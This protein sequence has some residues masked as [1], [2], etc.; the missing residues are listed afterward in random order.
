MSHILLNYAFLLFLSIY[1]E[2]HRELFFLD[3]KVTISETSTEILGKFVFLP[4][5]K[6]ANP[7]KNLDLYKQL[8]FDQTSERGQILTKTVFLPKMSHILLNY[9]FLLFWSFLGEIHGELF[10]LDKM[11]IS[12]TSTDILRKFVFL[13]ILKRVKSK[14]KLGYV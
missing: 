14:G 6:G 10:F 9:A 13:P 2:I 8:F 5:L 3:I 12:E 11:T 7:E 1:G 4:C